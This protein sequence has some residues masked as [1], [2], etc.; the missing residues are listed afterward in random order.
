MKHALLLWIVDALLRKPAPV[1]VLDTHA[2]IGRYDLLEGPAER[3]GEWRD[4]IARLLHDPPP[5]LQAYVQRVL[6]TP[7]RPGMAYLGSPL[8]FRALL[9]PQDRLTCCE[10]HQ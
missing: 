5:P 1:F 8:L 4:G 6:S 10:L 7:D 3:T 2:G 9:R